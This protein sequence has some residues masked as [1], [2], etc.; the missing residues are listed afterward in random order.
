MSGEIKE[1]F[2]QWRRPGLAVA[3]SGQDCH[4]SARLLL[5]PP[6]GKHSIHRLIMLQ[7]TYFAERAFANSNTH[8]H[9]G[10]INLPGTL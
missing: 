4:A 5:I 7:Q 2:V 9:L 3:N 1:E 8:S 10:G 6:L